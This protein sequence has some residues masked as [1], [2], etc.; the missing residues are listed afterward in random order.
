M[1]TAEID[2]IELAVS[3]SSS[4][5]EYTVSTINLP[6]VSFVIGGVPVVFKNSLSLNLRIETNEKLS[7][8]VTALLEDG[9]ISAGLEYK[10]GEGW[11]NLGSVNLPFQL[12]RPEFGAAFRSRN[13]CS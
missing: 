3:T 8:E 1:F 10:E 2:A 5:I 11:T 13:S 12:A 9:F 7:A 4:E 6:P